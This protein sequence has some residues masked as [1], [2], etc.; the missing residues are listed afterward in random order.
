MG[1]VFTSFNDFSFICFCYMASA[2]EPD[3]YVEDNPI[4]LIT[5]DISCTVSIAHIFCSSHLGCIKHPQ[6]AKSGKK[7]GEKLS[8][9]LHHFGTLTFFKPLSSTRCTDIKNTFNIILA[10]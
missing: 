3:L 7:G 2:F 10:N 1:T 9:L 8:N 4:S 6:K 5:H